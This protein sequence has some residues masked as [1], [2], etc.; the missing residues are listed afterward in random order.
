[1]RDPAVCREIQTKLLGHI[2]ELAVQKFSSNV[3]EKC[4]LIAAPD[5]RELITD[6]LIQPDRLPRLLQVGVACRGGLV[7]CDC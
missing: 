3:V 6:E 7:Y 5:V 4:L 1:M 2:S